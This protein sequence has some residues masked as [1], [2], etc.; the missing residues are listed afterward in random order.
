VPFDEQ[1]RLFKDRAH[2]IAAADDTIPA[3]QVIDQARHGLAPEVL[4]SIAADANDDSLA[5]MISRRRGGGMRL[6]NVLFKECQVPASYRKTRNGQ[7]FLAYDSAVLHPYLGR[8]I[9]FTSPSQV[10]ML[11]EADQVVSDGTFSSRPHGCGQKF[12]IRASIPRQ[13]GHLQGPNS[14]VEVPIA[15]IY[16]EK[17]TEEDYVEALRILIGMLP[18]GN[19]P[20]HWIADFELAQRNAVKRILPQLDYHFDYFH[21][22]QTL[23]RT[24]KRLRMRHFY[25]EE[26]FK[27]LFRELCCLP[28]IPP[29]EVQDGAVEAFHRYTGHF[30]EL[31][32]LDRKK[33]FKFLEYY[34]GNFMSHP[35]ARGVMTRPRYS[36]TEWNV[37]E[38]TLAGRSRVSNE[39]FNSGHNRKYHRGGRPR[40]SQCIKLDRK[41]EEKH[42][43][44]YERSRR[45]RTPVP[46]RGRR[47]RHEM[48][49]RLLHLLV[50]NYSQLEERTESSRQELLREVNRIKSLYQRSIGAYVVAADATA[51]NE[52]EVDDMI[53]DGL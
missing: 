20:K 22:C 47:I 9:L 25:G 26:A 36:A 44:L 2:E 16:M 8:S 24:V 40:F 50:T 4:D 11:A 41:M 21:Y 3:P 42:R 10:A 43:V 39:G 7:R 46:V 33:V 23:V 31:T 34:T 38:S 48:K 13:A 12:I 51:L 18:A 14:H 37:T 5:Q 19:R 15:T 27:L 53:L 6:D 52:Q 35:N 17:R 45:L 29:A 30:A 28:F 1:K 32:P 49:D